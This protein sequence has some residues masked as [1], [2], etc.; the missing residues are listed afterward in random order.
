MFGLFKSPPFHDAQLGDFTRS[1]GYW[2][3]SI[4]IENGRNLPLAV[5]GPR[6]EPD[7]QA[8]SIA[9][10]IAIQFPSWRPT[11]ETA[12]FEHYEPYGESLADDEPPPSSELVAGITSPALVWSHVSLVFVSV[13]P[14]D[15]VLT[16]E[17][18]YTTTWDEEHTL[19]AR[20][21]S[22]KFIELCG[23]VLAP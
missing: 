12:L 9:R 7:A 16:V 1:Q 21:Q 4:S 20:F 5:S 13:A 23:S 10:N 15:K 2:R 11:I 19:G 8:L 17:L 3:G 22:G 14:M 18:G 6:S